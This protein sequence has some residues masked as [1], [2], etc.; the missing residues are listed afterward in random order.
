MYLWCEFLHVI[1]DTDGV[2]ELD[3]W[4]LQIQFS[5]NH[6]N[7]REVMDPKRSE[8]NA[9]HILKSII[10]TNVWRE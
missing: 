1:C 4:Y 7:N 6:V 5:C 3:D 2:T 10:L 9:L 8:S